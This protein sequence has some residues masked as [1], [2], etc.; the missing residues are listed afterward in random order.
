MKL[1]CTVSWLHNLCVACTGAEPDN[2]RL[3]EA[4][5]VD[6]KAP[7]RCEGQVPAATATSLGFVREAGVYST[8][9]F[10]ATCAMASCAVCNMPP[11]NVFICGLE[12]CRLDGA[13]HPVHELNGIEDAER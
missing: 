2:G 8:S 5:V 12:R 11:C 4:A 10:G 3:E 1:R 7:G 6:V 9:S 13:L